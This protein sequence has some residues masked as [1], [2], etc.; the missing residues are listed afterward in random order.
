MC[1]TPVPL[2]EWVPVPGLTPLTPS[3]SSELAAT[4]PVTPY[5]VICY[6]GLH[7]GL[8]RAFA[9]GPPSDPEAVIVQHRLEPQEPEY[10]GRDPEAGWRLLSRIPGWT[11][12]NGS[13]EDMSEFGRIFAREMSVPFRQL[14]DLFYTLETPPRSHPNPSV[15]LLGTADIPLLRNYPPKVWGNSYRTFEE[16]LTEGV[17]G[18]AIV[19]G[20]VVSVAVLSANNGRYGDIGIHTLEPYRR[21]GYSTAA[22]SLVAREVQSRGITPIWSTGSDNVASQRVAAHVGFRPAGRGEYLVFD[23]LGDSGYRPA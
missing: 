11:C 20:H 16:M 14:G 2:P 8:D 23:G 17:V 4:L 15:R 10:F 13:T 22:A 12:L 5:F 9:V 6:A 19:D 1:P 3:E 21:R 18:G 7:R